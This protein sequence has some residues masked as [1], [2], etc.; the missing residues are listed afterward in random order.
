MA[1]WLHI[2]YEDELY[3]LRT[4]VLDS[5]SF[6]DILEARV[7]LN[8]WLQDEVSNVWMR[9]PRIEILRA[10]LKD[11]CKEKSC[12]LR[13]QASSVSPNSSQNALSAKIASGEQ[14]E[15]SDETVTP[16][17]DNI[18][19][20][21]TQVSVNQL[22]MDELVI[23]QQNES[24][25]TTLLVHAES[26]LTK[27]RLDAE[28]GV[29]PFD[30]IIRTELGNGECKDVQLTQQVWTNCLLKGRHVEQFLDFVT[31]GFK[32]LFG[33]DDKLKELRSNGDLW[34]R[35][36][37]FHFDLMHFESSQGRLEQF[38]GEYCM[39]ERY[40]SAQELT[41][42]LDFPTSSGTTTRQSLAA[43]FTA[44]G[45]IT[46]VC[47]SHDVAPG[48]EKIYGIRK[49]FE[50]GDKV[51]KKYFKAFVARKITF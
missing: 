2:D 49:G 42:L 29:S 40:F 25:S 18:V 17:S 41:Y 37:C 27:I 44:K 35:L 43:M 7:L 51:F 13:F 5:I 24:T 8:C 34:M 22:C 15:P 45:N 9:I 21:F 31:T 20:P 16:V 36:K 1:Y 14:S 50:S 30:V 19:E 4:S 47:T 28:R 39:S 23:V 26:L 33:L 12:K 38:G 11:T 46:A 3:Q 32:N 48:I 10:L 6:V